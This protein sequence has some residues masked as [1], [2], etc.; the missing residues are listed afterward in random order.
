MRLLISASL[1]IACVLSNAGE[2]L[3]ATVKRVVDGDTIVVSTE[4]GEQKV[5]LLRVNTPESVHPDQKQNNEAGRA[6]SKWVAEQLLGKT[7]ELEKE[8]EEADQHGR[9]LR[10][11]FLDGRNFCV[12]IVRAG[13]SPY[14]TAF[15][16][17]KYREEFEKA[18]KEARDQKLAIWSDAELTEKYLRLKSKWGKDAKRADAKETAKP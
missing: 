6:A 3:T 4:G 8:T 14:Y 2:C 10:Y 12:A 17:G 13:H 16:H 5:R 7:V 11:I 9:L 1:C 15:G 18:E